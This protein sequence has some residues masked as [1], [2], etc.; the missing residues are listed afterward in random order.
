VPI[1]TDVV[2]AGAGAAGLAAARELRLLGIPHVVVE[3]KPIV[4]GRTFCDPS[5]ILSMAG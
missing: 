3:A 5:R 1:K 4:G 2:V